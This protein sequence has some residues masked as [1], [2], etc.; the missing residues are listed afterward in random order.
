[1]LRS[2]EQ[3]L[4]SQSSDQE[5]CDQL[6]C[7]TCEV[8]INFLR[9]DVEVV[10]N[11]WR[12]QSSDQESCAQLSGAMLTSHQARSSSIPGQLSGS[13]RVR[14]WS[15][16]WLDSEPESGQLFGQLSG[17]ISGQKLVNFLARFRA[18]NLVKFRL[19]SEPKSSSIPGP[20][21]TSQEVV[22]RPGTRPKPP[23]PGRG[24]FRA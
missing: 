9:I 6:S 8:V 12:S 23:L 14:N 13:N 3:L 7:A 21:L 19:D 15:T 22:S 11:F 10:T 5:S 24:W 2:C 4:R 18:R 16:F 20:K 17:P 1:M